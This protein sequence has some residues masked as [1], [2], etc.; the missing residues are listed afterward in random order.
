MPNVDSTEKLHQLWDKMPNP[1]EA[2]RRPSSIIEQLRREATE[3]ELA[4]QREGFG[5]GPRG[6]RNT[7]TDQEFA[8]F[9][10]RNARRPS[11]ACG[12]SADIINRV[13]TEFSDG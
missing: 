4:K 2:E 3:A 5:Q 6:P 8:D 7:M 10:E 1:D 9:E 12:K 11:D 13:F